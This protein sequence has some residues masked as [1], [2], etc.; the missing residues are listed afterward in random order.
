MTRAPKDPKAGDVLLRHLPDLQHMTQPHGAL[1]KP[2]WAPLRRM[3][4]APAIGTSLLPASLGGLGRSVLGGM[5][6]CGHRA[7]RTVPGLYGVG[8]PLPCT[9]ARMPP[10]S[11][12]GP[13]GMLAAEGWMDV[14]DR[15]LVAAMSSSARPT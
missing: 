4:H 8:G 10:D 1:S 7:P 11:L 12:C 5:G 14:P 15:E 2:L 13:C 3:R 6:R 9:W